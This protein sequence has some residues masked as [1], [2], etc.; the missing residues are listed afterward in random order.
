[1]VVKDTTVRD[2][3]KSSRVTSL[4]SP[5]EN[6]DLVC[7]LAVRFYFWD[8]TLP[9]RSNP[10]SSL[11]LHLTSKAVRGTNAKESRVKVSVHSFAYNFFTDL[12]F[13]ADLGIFF[14]APPGVSLRHI[15]TGIVV[16]LT[17]VPRPL[18]P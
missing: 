10:R 2:T 9:Q 13:A 3:N 7:A 11:E 17:L 6:K 4:L 1:M 8:L 12:D 16:Y 14:K 15:S 18:K 5:A